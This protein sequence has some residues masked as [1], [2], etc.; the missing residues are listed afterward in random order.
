VPPARPWSLP[1]MFG[2]AYLFWLRFT[3]V[4]PVLVRNLGCPW[5]LPSIF[6]LALGL[7]GMA[8]VRDAGPCHESEG[9]RVLG[10]DDSRG[11]QDR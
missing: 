3:Y 6:G 8:F 7:A 2:L 9:R 5:S 10:I 1:S 4:T 11:R